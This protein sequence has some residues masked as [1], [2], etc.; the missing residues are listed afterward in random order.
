MSEGLEVKSTGVY[1]IEHI[2]SGKKYVGSAAKS[3]K[4]RWRHHRYQLR[5]GTH[6]SI[7]LQRAWN[8]YGE[9]AFAF[10]ILEVTKPEHA[11]AVEQTFIDWLKSI[12][13]RYGFNI[14]PKADSCRGVKHGVAVRSACSVR[15]KKLL[16]SR[17][18][19]AAHSARLK[20]ATGTPEYRAKA[21]SQMKRL[22][23]TPEYRAEASSRMKKW[24][25]SPESRAAMSARA[26]SAQGTPES[27][28]ARAV[29]MKKRF[30]SPE[31]RANHS[32]SQ[33]TRFA[34]QE[35]RA[36]HS[37]RLKTLWADPVF[38]SIQIMNRRLKLASK[39]L[40]VLSQ[41]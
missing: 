11:V 24:C 29:S 16:E 36:E 20:L 28:A 37:E 25:A 9:S 35:S 27:R 39:C 30:Q 15:M 8:K 7:I 1:V 26:K 6:H 41:E 21:S 38:K 34:S 13:P 32:A 31:Y 2:A 33:K 3:I 12:D 22:W 14:A 18:A 17:E 19:R 4:A 5:K 23:R 10:R 40:V